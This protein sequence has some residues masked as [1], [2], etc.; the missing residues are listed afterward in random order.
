M[1]SRVFFAVIIVGCIVYGIIAENGIF[2]VPI[3]ILVAYGLVGAPI[4]IAFNIVIM[5]VYKS[6][7]KHHATSRGLEEFE[8]LKRIK[9]E[10]SDSGS[11]DS[12]Y[13]NRKVNDSCNNNTTNNNQN[14]DSWDD[15]YF[16]ADPRYYDNN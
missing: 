2:D 6:F 14:D 15:Y 8:R 3:A 4:W 16:L 11:G 12:Y 10:K 7:E 5:I 1:W 9:I 13:T